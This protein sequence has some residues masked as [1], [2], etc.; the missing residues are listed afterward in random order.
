MFCL[1]AIFPGGVYT[2]YPEYFGFFGDDTV[3]Y[4]DNRLL[5]IMP[6]TT[7]S[8][9]IDPSI[10]GVITVDSESDTTTYDI[11]YE[12]TGSVGQVAFVNASYAGSC[13]NFDYDATLPWSYTFSTNDMRSFYVSSRFREGDAG[14]LTAT[15]YID[16]IKV[17]SYTASCEQGECSGVFA[18]AAFNSTNKF[19]DAI[20]GT[21]IRWENVP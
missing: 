6:G 2:L 20:Q 15:I 5:H 11:R 14:S 4:H 19:V 9:A 1:H 3:H 18:T 10:I 8:I 7:C 12:V 13:N 16:D 21:L 17:Y